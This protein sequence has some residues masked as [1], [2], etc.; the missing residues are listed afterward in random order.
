MMKFLSKYAATF[1]ALI[2]LLNAVCLVAVV[3]MLIPINNK[4]NNVA[5]EVNCEFFINVQEWQNG[6]AVVYCTSATSRSQKAIQKEY[7][8]Q[9]ANSMQ[10]CNKLEVCIDSSRITMYEDCSSNY[11]IVVKKDTVIYY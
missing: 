2:P 7:E 4:L 6:T 11:D 10:L 9:V 1:T 3:F 8:E 5:H